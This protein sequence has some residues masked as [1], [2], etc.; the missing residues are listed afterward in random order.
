MNALEAEYTILKDKCAA[1]GFYVDVFDAE[2]P[3][4]MC[5]LGGKTVEEQARTWQIR[6]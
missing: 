3:T 4:T 2:L 1:K 6:N 5:L